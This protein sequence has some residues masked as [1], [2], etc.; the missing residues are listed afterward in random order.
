[1]MQIPVLP[2][3]AFRKGMNIAHALD[4]AAVFVIFDPVALSRRNAELRPNYPRRAHVLNVN[5]P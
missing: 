1:M 5:R 3:S 2:R 4:R